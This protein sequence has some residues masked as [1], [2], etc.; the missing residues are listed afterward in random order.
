MTQTVDLQQV[1]IQGIK[2]LPQQYLDEVA[3]FVFFLREKRIKQQMP[4]DENQERKEA[5]LKWIA[6]NRLHAPK[7][8][9]S[10]DIRALIDQTHDREI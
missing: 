4:N 1:I 5:M 9:P 7:I 10:I 8:D 3:D 6:H 2:D